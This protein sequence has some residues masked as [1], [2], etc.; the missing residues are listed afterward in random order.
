M[1]EATLPLELWRDKLMNKRWEIVLWLCVV[2]LSA[3]GCGEA[4]KA[5]PGQTPAA[6][7]GQQPPVARSAA[8]GWDCAALLS[9]QDVER[10]VGRGGA[11]IVSSVRG[12]A[13]P[14]AP[15]HTECGFFVPPAGGLH[16]FINTGPALAPESGYDL[17]GS[18]QGYNVESLNGIGDE[19]WMWELKGNSVSAVAIAKGAEV[20]VGVGNEGDRGKE[21]AQ[22]LLEI[23]VSRL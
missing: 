23:V 22:R 6:V 1:S 19:A 2:A 10:I 4:D 13:N 11:T 18:A 8:R 12:D 20:F 7:S 15:G 21:I 3:A 9:P 5:V 17:R 16:F 14:E